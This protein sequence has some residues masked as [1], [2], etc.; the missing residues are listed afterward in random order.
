VLGPLQ[1]KW[2]E[3]VN[4]QKLNGFGT[5]KFIPAQVQNGKILSVWPPEVAD[6]TYRPAPR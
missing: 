4:G 5:Q 2:N 1:F 3:T 6:A